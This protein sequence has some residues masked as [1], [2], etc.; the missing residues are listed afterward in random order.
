MLMFLVGLEIILVIRDLGL[1]VI[2]MAILLLVI[3]IVLSL[4]IVVI[5]LLVITMAI[6]LEV[7]V[8]EAKGMVAIDLSS[9]VIDL[10]ITGQ[11][12]LPLDRI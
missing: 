9:M 8:T 10:V 12:T 6:H 4:V 2:I 7:M 5:I 3:P 11:V 1:L